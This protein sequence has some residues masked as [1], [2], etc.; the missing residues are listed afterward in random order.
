MEQLEEKVGEQTRRAQGSYDK[1][2]CRAR[3]LL[4]GRTE[5]RTPITVR[6]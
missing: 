4:V 3:Q 6:E 5:P 1:G 2:G